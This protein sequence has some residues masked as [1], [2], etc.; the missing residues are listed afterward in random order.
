MSKTWKRLLSLLLAVVMMLSL[1]VTGFADFEEETP[2]ETPEENEVLEPEEEAVE[3]NGELEM[4]EISPDK[5]NVPKLGLE[6]G[7]EDS[8]ELIPMDEEDLNQVVRV[9][10]FLEAPSTISAGFSTEGIGTNSAA[11][12]YRE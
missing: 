10:I 11:I 2:A 9:S 1:G 5:L 6:E 3:D 7:E 4:T 8:E 12:A